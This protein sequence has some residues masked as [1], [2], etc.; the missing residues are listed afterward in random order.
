MAEVVSCQPFTAE[1]RVESHVSPCEFNGCQGGTGTDFY[2][3]TSVFPCHY[4]FT[5][6]HVN[7]K[8]TSMPAG[9][10]YTYVD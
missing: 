9:E 2:S 7:T 3:S 4:H 6:V 10:A 8:L 1:S 5:N